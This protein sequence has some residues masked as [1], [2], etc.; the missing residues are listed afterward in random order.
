ME[1]A[2]EQ[3]ALRFR[4]MEAADLRLLHE[5]LHRPH[6]QRWW[7]S[8]ETF[9]EVTQHYLPAIEGKELTDHYVVLLDEQS[10]GLVQTYLVSD[11]PDYSAVVGVGEGAAGV[12]LFIA[13][14][15]LTGQGIGTEIL[16]RFVDEI[17][18]ASPTTTSCVAD[19]DVRNVASICAFEKAGFRIVNE[20]V[21]PEHGQR[22]ALVCRER[23]DSIGAT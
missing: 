14:V 8:R 7:N 23:S 15:E 17:V 5:W 2:D 1:V 11:Y 18:F 6:V 20:F 4:S 9:E 10:I 19:P 12:D 13:E 3:R 21:D 16:R 22:H